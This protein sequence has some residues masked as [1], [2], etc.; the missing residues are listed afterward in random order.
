MRTGTSWLALASLLL[1]SGCYHVKVTAE[2]EPGADLS[3]IETFAHAPRDPAV[4]SGPESRPVSEA[5]RAQIDAELTGKG[6]RAAPLESADIVV[7][8]Q[9]R[10]V[11]RSRLQDAGDPDATFYV[12]RDYVEG[13]LVIDVFSAG[14]SRP[15]WHGVGTVDFAHESNAPRAARRAVRDILARFP[16]EPGS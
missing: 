6:Y 5:V 1:A 4:D 2:A 16:P 9:A 10:G 3:G 7:A 15:A 14:R 12:V 13:T 11:E 8:F